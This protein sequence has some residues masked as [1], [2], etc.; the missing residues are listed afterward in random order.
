MFHI[1]SAINILCHQVNIL[2]T[3]ICIWNICFKTKFTLLLK[4]SIWIIEFMNNILILS[5]WIIYWFCLIIYSWIQCLFID[6]FIVSLKK[7]FNIRFPLFPVCIF[8]PCLLSHCFCYIISIFRTHSRH[9]NP[10]KINLSLTYTI[11]KI[12]TH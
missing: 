3:C 12:S 8:W 7:D 6:R 2:S 9:N 4:Q 11:V 10:N 1:A 5:L